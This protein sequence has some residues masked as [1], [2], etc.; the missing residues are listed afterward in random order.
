MLDSGGVEQKKKKV[1]DNIH[2]IFEYLL[3]YMCVE[4]VS[5]TR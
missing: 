5:Q 2:C 3:L 1:M 4:G